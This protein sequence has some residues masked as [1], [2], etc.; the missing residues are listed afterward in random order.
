[1]FN[2]LGAKKS[3]DTLKDRLKIVLTYDR[4]K[5]APG[6]MEELKAELLEV[7][8]KYFPFRKDAIDVQI[9]QEGDNMKLVANLP[10]Q[11]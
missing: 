10:G 3:K 9:E 1:M 2:I 11:L 4:A 7:V 5:I 8:E 6:K